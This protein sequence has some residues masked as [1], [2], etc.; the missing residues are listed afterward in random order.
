MLEAWAPAVLS[1]YG[2]LTWEWWPSNA[3]RGF[4][5]PL[6]FAAVYRL[7]A[8]AHWDS[9]FL[10]VSGAALNLP[11]SIPSVSLWILHRALLQV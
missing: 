4:L 6:L 11:R 8:L 1:R 10:V 5:H 7:L 3:L 9:A 2:H